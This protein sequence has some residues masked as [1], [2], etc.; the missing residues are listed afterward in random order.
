LLGLPGRKRLAASTPDSNRQEG[1]QDGGESA[2]ERQGG[3]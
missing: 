3:G 2:A 1:E